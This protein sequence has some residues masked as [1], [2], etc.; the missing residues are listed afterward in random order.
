MFYSGVDVKGFL[1]LVICDFNFVVV[2][3]Y[4]LVY[5][6]KFDV[7][8]EDDYF[9]FIGKVKVVC[10]GMDVML[11]VY[12]WLVLFVLEVVEVLVV[13]GIDVEVVDFRMLCLMDMEMFV[14]FV[15]KMN[16]VVIIEEGWGLCGIGVEILVILMIDVFDYLDVLVVCVY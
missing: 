2:F 16:R 12:S 11:I 1:K 15:K 3:E 8:I 6:N 4:E 9:V 14:K 7:L 5:G 10:F 13:D